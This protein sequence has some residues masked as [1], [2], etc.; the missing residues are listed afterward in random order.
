[1]FPL[2]SVHPLIF[3][4]SIKMRQVKVKVNKMKIYPS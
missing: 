2:L 4:I 3:F 1:M